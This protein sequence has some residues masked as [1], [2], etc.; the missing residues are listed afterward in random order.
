MCFM[1]CRWPQSQEGDWARLHLCKLAR[2]GP[3]PVR[4]RFIRDHVWRGRSKP[5]RRIV[6]SVTIVWLTTEADDQS[7]LHC[8]TVN[9]SRP[10]RRK[11]DWLTDDKYPSNSNWTHLGLG[12]GSQHVVLIKS[13]VSLV[14]AVDRATKSPATQRLVLHRTHLALLLLTYLPTCTE[15]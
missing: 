15:K 1:V 5:V 7:S 14:H 12:A 11:V 13:V 2:H 6:G 10:F 8:T 9:S 3:W 4:K